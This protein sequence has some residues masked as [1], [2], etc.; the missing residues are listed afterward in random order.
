MNRTGWVLLLLVLGTSP[1]M[2]QDSANFVNWENHPVHAMDLS[3]DGTLLAVA[4]T[5]DARVQLFDVSTGTAVFAGSVSV[6]LDPVS[7]RF[8]TNGE[9]WVVNHISDSVSIVDVANRQVKAT[10]ATLDEPYDVVFAG[11]GGRAFVSCSQANRI[12]VFNPASLGSPAQVVELNA[13]DPRALAVSSDGATVYA[14]I[15]ESGNA[16]TIVAG[17]T[18]TS[19]YPPNGAREASGPYGGV[20]PPPNSGNG[21]S[22]EINPDL[23]LEPL[24]GQIVRKDDA[25]NWMDDNNG[26]WTNLVSG[27][28]AGL[29]G[30]V[31]GWDMPDRDIAVIDANSLS[32]SY[33]SRLGN[34]GMALSINPANGSLLWLGT[35]ATNEVRFEPNV[36]GTFLRV[37][38]ALVTPGGQRSVLDLNPHLDYARPTVAQN[39]RDLSL[40]DPRGGA[41]LADGSAAFVAGM[42]SNNVITLNAD[43]S[44]N[45]DIEPIEVG[46]G[47][48]AVVVSADQQ[49]LFVWN[50]FS[51]ELS[52]VDIEAGQ[53]LTRIAAHNPLP[54]AIRAGRKHFYSTH[55]TSGLGHLACASCHVDGKSDRLAWDLGDPAGE[56]KFFNQNCST[57]RVGSVCRAF[58]PMKGPMVTQT[59]QDIIGN[60]PFHWRGDRDGIEEF[61]PAYMVLQG[62]D[63]QLSETE[64]QEFE[65][66]LDTITIPPNPFRNFNNSL[67][68]SLPLDGHFTTGRFGPAGQPLGSGNAVRGLD[69]F[70]NE[71]LVPVDGADPTGC[72]TC[73]TTPT[74]MGSNGTLVDTFNDGVPIGGQNLP[75]GP[76]GENHL[77]ISGLGTVSGGDFKV[78]QLRTLYEKTGF[79]MDNAQSRAGFGFL[80]DG[81]VDTLAEFVALGDFIPSSD[82]DVAD[83]V[84]LMLSF[85]GSD[86]GAGNA[87]HNNFPPP[88]QDTHAAVGRQVTVSSANVPGRVNEMLSL[89]DTGAI[90]VVAHLSGSSWLYDGGNFVAA[91]GSAPVAL[92]ALTAGA[93][94]ASPL[95]LTAVPRGSGLRLGLDRDGDGVSD[96]VEKQQGSDP[97]DPASSTFG[98]DQGLWFNPSRQ[99]HGIDLQRS[100]NLLA[101]TWY[102]YLDDGTPTWYQAVGEFQGTSWTADLLSYRLLEDGS[103]E[104]TTVGTMNFEFTSPGAAT[105]N[106]TLGDRSGSEPF[107]RFAFS[108][109]RTLRQYTGLWFDPAEPG[110]G[111]TIDTRGDVRVVVAYFYDANNQPRWTI[112]QSTNSQTGAVDMLSVNGFCPDCQFVPTSTAAGGALTLS[113]EEFERKTGLEMAVDYPDVADSLFER[114]A[115]MVPLSDKP[116]DF[117]R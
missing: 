91:D 25:G 64:M 15:F 113:F 70:I 53:E 102:T 37:Q 28:Q 103:L 4:H 85:S 45:T 80:H 44:R 51:A 17:G 26:N 18:E 74:G 52:V 1:L 104:G 88:S 13:E 115:E 29:S 3:P 97:A 2:A 24:V 92:A 11:T 41:W 116:V 23:S 72:N 21:F 112:G 32:V 77:H 27:S 108:N 87:A 54:E 66:F 46:E 95:T 99:G 109:D 16:T 105:F 47:P 33:I 31:T 9:L 61:N 111:L 110:Y 73:H 60:E 48:V 19:D 63:E 89:A 78:P 49:R 76:N 8:R 84:A 12:Q 58:H 57:N 71:P 22:P 7:V 62:D 10:L 5:A 42:G 36:N 40:G 14:A 43:G 50:H 38:S 39:L 114:N 35:D 101:G 55:E 82:Q 90:D 59:L 56:F 83:L 30:R 79:D 86:L 34:I 94:G 117:E 69:L 100:G 65:D 93:S 107:E 68:S 106:W 20:N 81:S 96:G 67:K 75:T 98:P 6:G